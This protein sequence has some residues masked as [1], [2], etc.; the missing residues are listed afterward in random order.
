MY[1][2][3]RDDGGTTWDTD[4]WSLEQCGRGDV[5]PHGAPY[6]GPVERLD[7]TPSCSVVV[8]DTTV[9]GY[10]DP[11]GP[12]EPQERFW[13]DEFDPARPVPRAMSDLVIY[14][15]HVGALA[16]NTRAAGTFADALELL[17]YLEDLGVNAVELLPMLEFNGSTSW[18]YGSSHF[19]AIESSAGG[20]DALKHFVRACHRRGIAVLMDV[21]YNH[22][23]DDS[24]RAAWQPDSLAPERNIYYWYE[25]SPADHRS[26]DGGYLDNWSSGAAPR[27]WADEVRALF[28]SSAALLLDEFHLDG[29]RVDQ[30]TSIHAYNRLRDDGRPAPAANIWGRKF[31]RQLCQTLK[32]VDP[33]VL[34]VAED[35]SGWPAVTQPSHT[36]GVGFDA[37][38]HVDFYRHLV[39][40]K[41]EGPEHAKLLDMAAR[42]DR[43]PLAMGRFAAQLAATGPHTV[44]YVENHD[45]AG[46]APDTRRT[47]RVAVNDAPLV[48]ATRAVAEARCRLAAAM[49]FL[50]PGVPLFLM[51][52]EVGAQQGYTYD[53]F[54]E[55][56][57]DLLGLRETSGR[58]LFRCHADLIRFR[59]ASSAIR[60]GT[61]DVLHA[62]DAGRVL[63]FR[64]ADAADEVVVVGS[65][66]TEPY[67]HPGY[68][69]RH[70]LL[71][72]AKWQEC[73]NT[74]AVEYGGAGVG[75]GGAVLRAEGGRL[76]VVVPASGV[77]VLRRLHAG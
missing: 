39:G 56:K 57:E 32:T 8:D 35:H 10:P 33:T 52:E 16:P 15:L 53:R 73:L 72:N 25:G 2:V 59:L 71:E 50:S 75:N 74:D 7:G 45:E 13:A 29:F 38:W 55:H 17:P 23:N 48:G 44:V 22:Y 70:P 1:R 37:A 49:T 66:A 77:V 21:V 40:D 6:A 18:G 36:G 61:I 12:A 47:I 63:A 43:G 64:R 20:R 27:Y 58:G 31:L 65:L 69:L 42:N 46:N 76:D 67:D 60:I 68:T 24:A 5:D 28:V 41:G 26:P 34:L 4:M 54:V 11:V 14:E 19:L 3:V 30:T 51:G 62:D 9:A